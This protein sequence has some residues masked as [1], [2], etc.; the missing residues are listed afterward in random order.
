MIFLESCLCPEKQKTLRNINPNVELCPYLILSYP[1]TTNVFTNV[2]H[3]TYYVQRL[4][5]TQNVTSGFPVNCIHQAAVWFC[6][7]VWAPHGTHDDSYLLS[8]SWQNTARITVSLSSNEIW[9]WMRL[10]WNQEHP[11]QGCLLALV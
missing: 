1:P 7:S 8:L 10:Q 9:V 3:S 5:K 11:I 6:S 2:P 4:H